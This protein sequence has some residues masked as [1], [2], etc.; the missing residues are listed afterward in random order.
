V[1]WKSP[2][3][4][5]VQADC[6][7]GLKHSTAG[8]VAAEVELDQTVP[9]QSSNSSRARSSSSPAT[10]AAAPIAHPSVN[11]ATVSGSDR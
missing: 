9:G 7:D 6:A 2:V 5:E 8:T 1:L 3:I 10:C 11:T 4:G